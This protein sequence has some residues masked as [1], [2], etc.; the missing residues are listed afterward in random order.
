MQRSIL[1]PSRSACSLARHT[2]AARFT[3]S[4]NIRCYATDI[5]VQPPEYLDAGEKRVFGLL[6]EGLRPSKLEV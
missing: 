3:P 1:M 4:N 2:T 5:D 6:K